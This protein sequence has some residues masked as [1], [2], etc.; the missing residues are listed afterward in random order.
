MDI[1]FNDSGGEYLKYYEN[2]RNHHYSYAI[3]TFDYP[4]MHGHVDYWEFCIVTEGTLKNCLESGEVTLCTERNVFLMSTK[5]RHFLIK[6]SPRIRYIN[7]SVRESHLL[8]MLNVISPE[9]EKKLL[10]ERRAFQ[11]SE[12]LLLEVENLLHQCNLLSEKQV[13]EKNGLLCSAVL[14]L[15]QEL[16]GIQLKVDERLCPF[17]QKLFCVA[18]KRE[19]ITYTAADLQ[20]ALNYSPA[21]LNRLFKEH[22]N[23]TPYEYLQKRKFRYAW[24]LLKNTDMSMQKIAFEIGY[25]NLSHFFANFK[26]YYGITP[27]EC[28][29]G[30]LSEHEGGKGV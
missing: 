30:C 8:R 12:N 10:E 22:L 11:I 27:G 29:K 19:F 5:D 23:M 24:N 13:S 18:E 9:L 4:M 14:P 6:E 25:S 3:N 17:M 28:R 20:K 7:I 2:D 21:H 1:S 26:K 15:V 16:N